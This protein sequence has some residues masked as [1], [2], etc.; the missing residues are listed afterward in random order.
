MEPFTL[1]FCPRLKKMLDSGHATLPNGSVIP[2][3]GTSTLNNIQIIRHFVLTRRPNNTLEIGLAYGASALT[4]LG[5]LREIND[6]QFRH[7]AIDPFQSTIW[8]RVALYCISEERFT[9][10]FQHYEEESCTALPRL[11][12]EGKQ[13]DII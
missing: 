2:T 1:D 3:T 5:S 6:G 9:D 11:Y 10:N 4:F 8:Q 13:F 12:S 7:S